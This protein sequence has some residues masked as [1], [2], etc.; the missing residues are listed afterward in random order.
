MD[1]R[2]LGPLEV[3]FDDGGLAV[4]PRRERALV[5]VLLV[6]AWSPVSRDTVARALWDD[7]PPADIAAQLRVCLCR[8]RSALG[9]A[10]RCLTARQGA[11]LADPV[12]E[13]LDLAR[14]RELRAS[15][16]RLART[17]ALRQ[18]SLALREALA[19][20]RDPPL[21]DL[22]DTP[23]LTAERDRL[24][25]QR[26]AAVLD[27]TDLLLELGEHQR[28]VADLNARVVADP[29]CQHSWAQFMLALYRCGRKGDALAAY[30]K[31]TAALRPPH[32][33]GPG[34]EL[35]AMLH[36]I[37]TDWQ[38]GTDVPA[39]R[40]APATARTRAALAAGGPGLPAAI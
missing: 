10:G 27:L 36:G 21:A 2:V 15:A 12:A 17:G 11:Y 16:D 22:P 35:Q 30:T 37:L 8:A 25:A 26:Q 39:L 24:L 6:S 31:A 33:Y 4:V 7:R 32:G 20:W 34:P 5:A 28:V 29:Q 14:F 18:A 23:E 19:C 40:T 1:W 3:V 9:P 13:D 38:G